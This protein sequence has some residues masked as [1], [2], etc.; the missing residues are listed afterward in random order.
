LYRGARSL[1]LLLLLLLL[2]AFFF[3]ASLFSWAAF[4]SSSL[5]AA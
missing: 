5:S 2:L 1:L 4:E 3:L